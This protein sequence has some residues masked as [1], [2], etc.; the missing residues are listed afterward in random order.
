VNR[1]ILIAAAAAGA[2]LIVGTVVWLLLPRFYSGTSAPAQTKIGELVEQNFP[3]ERTADATEAPSVTSAPLVRLR[4]GVVVKVIGIMQGE[5]WLQIQLPNN[6]IGYI[7]IVAIP[8]VRGPGPP[9]PAAKA[10]S[11]VEF[12]PAAERWKVATQ[13]PA[14]SAPDATARPLYPVEAGRLVDVI[15]K[16]K[17]GKWAWVRTADDSPAYM[18]LA[19]LTPVEVEEAAP[20]AVPSQSAS[21]PLPPQTASV[22]PPPPPSPPPLPDEVSGQAQAI[23]TSLLVVDGQKISLAGLRGQGGEYRDQFQSLIEAKGGTLSCRRQHGRQYTCQFPSGDDVGRA[24]LYNGGARVGPGASE[25]YPEQA[26][27]AQDGHRG[28]WQ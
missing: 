5:S 11:A 9:D 22:Q 7:P 21:A 17:D 23:T 6:Q 27:A 25:D 8:S 20:S 4:E 19:S 13:S 3:V 10:A 2:L 28:I 18:Q 16:S 14:F 26:K 15:A 24:V 1:Q 12:D